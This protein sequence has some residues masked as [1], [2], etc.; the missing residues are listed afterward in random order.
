MQKWIVSELPS[1]HTI[2]AQFPIISV[3]KNYLH[4]PK[5]NRHRLVPHKDKLA[6]LGQLLCNKQAHHAATC[7][8]LH[9]DLRSHIKCETLFKVNYEYRLHLHNTFP[10]TLFKVPE[11]M[12]LS[13]VD[14]SVLPDKFWNT[15]SFSQVKQ[16]HT[17]FKT[18]MLVVTSLC[19]WYMC[20]KL[21]PKSILKICCKGSIH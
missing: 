16:I 6:S 2:S 12:V 10:S 15:T 17:Y 11:S 18:K 5:D 8:M 4:R 9:E 14:R 19:F 20:T 21:Y 1:L 7:D 3:H 13:F